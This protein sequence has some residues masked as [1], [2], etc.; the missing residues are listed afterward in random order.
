MRDRIIIEI[1][2]ADLTEEACDA[3]INPVNIYLSSRAGL[4]GQ[5]VMTW[6]ELNTLLKE[7]RDRKQ[8]EVVTT[9][10]C[11]VT[12][13]GGSLPF[14]H[15][16]HTPGP[17]WRNYR[18]KPRKAAE[19]LQECLKNTLAK[20]KALP[21]VRVI[22]MPPISAGNNG[23]NMVMVAHII[24]RQIF[25]WCYKP[26]GSDSGKIQSIRIRNPDIE[27][28]L[29]WQKVLRELFELA[30]GYADIEPEYDVP[31]RAETSDSDSRGSLRLGEDLPNLRGEVEEEEK[32]SD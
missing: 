24:L 22:N 15:P 26:P 9:G 18:E 2:I 19:L 4:S 21:D 14:K 31:E 16:L 12:V 6:P 13:A 11:E 28:H 29:V 20:A 1:G 17:I 32:K 7:I 27:G 3:L 5:L 10:S 23:G 30:I 25:E 8:P